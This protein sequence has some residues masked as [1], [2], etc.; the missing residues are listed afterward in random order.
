MSDLLDRIKLY[1]VWIGKDNSQEIIDLI[2]QQQARIAELEQHEQELAATVDVLREYLRS[3]VEES[4]GVIGWHL[5]GA[6]ADWDEV[7]ATDILG[8]T[9]NANLNAVKREVA[10]AAVKTALINL[11]EGSLSEQDISSF[12]KLYANTNY[13]SGK[14]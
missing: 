7:G 3:L 12:A 1:S 6:V 4:T 14:E 9:N 11:G 2:E 13:P 5:N 10:K 8:E